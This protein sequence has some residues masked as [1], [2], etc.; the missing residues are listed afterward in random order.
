MKAKDLREFS[1]EELLDKHINI[2]KELHALNAQRQLGN[3]D[4]PANFGNLRKD[5]ARILTVIKESE[6][7]T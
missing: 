2:K 7:K 4:K 5:I 1:K 3:V 6:S